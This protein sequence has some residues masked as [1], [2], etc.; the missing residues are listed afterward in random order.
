MTMS[1][2]TTTTRRRSLT[3][4]FAAL[5]LFAG[6]RSAHA[7]GFISPFYGYNFG[8]DAG[9]PEITNC[10][11]KRTDYGVSFGALGSIVGFEAELGYTKNF[12]GETLGSTS[13]VLTFMGNFMLAPK[14]GPVQPY[15][16]AGVGLIR[17][18]VEGV[19]TSNDQNQAGWDVGG[20]LMIFFGEHIGARGDV[21]YF[22]SF[23]V[24]D[25]LNLPNL[26]S[27][28]LGGQKLDYGRAAAAV[29]FKF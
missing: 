10:Q 7:Q 1:D 22:H 18:T 15:G 3:V 17:T 20:G 19:G 27:L 12:F 26:P 25:F 16:L 24:L 28:G 14:I 8:G 2:R 5:L 11:D 13:N 4:L 6:A 21:R 23:Q 29:V 9:C